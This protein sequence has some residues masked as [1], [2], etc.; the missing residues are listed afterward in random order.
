[1]HSFI[2]VMHAFILI[3][4]LFVSAHCFDLS[5]AAYFT[6]AVGFACNQ[7][8]SQH[9]QSNWLGDELVCCW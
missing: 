8:C 6:V 9:F 5:F 2:L 7:P 3:S 4:L 1:M